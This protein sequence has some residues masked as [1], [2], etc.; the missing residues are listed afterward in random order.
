MEIWKD[1][2]N[3]NKEKY[4]NE[5]I[6]LLKIPSISADSNYIGDTRKAAE[7]VAERLKEAGADSIELKET[8]GG[9]VVNPDFP[10]NVTKAKFD[11]RL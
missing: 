6:E 5:L 4:L 7:F 9:A 2:D 11:I 8:L 1:Y 3:Q 10:V